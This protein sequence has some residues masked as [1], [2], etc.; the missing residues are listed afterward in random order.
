MATIKSEKYDENQ[1]E[2]DYEYYKNRDN[3]SDE[4]IYFILKERYAHRSKIAEKKLI[5]ALKKSELNKE[6]TNEI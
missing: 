3:S 2:R 4:S 5:E 6:T 1:V